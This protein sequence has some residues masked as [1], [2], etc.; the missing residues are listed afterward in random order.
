[1]GERSTID[2]FTIGRRLRDEFDVECQPLPSQMVGLLIELHKKEAADAYR[3][4]KRERR[5]S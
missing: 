3:L 5:L 2:L 4:S 1:M